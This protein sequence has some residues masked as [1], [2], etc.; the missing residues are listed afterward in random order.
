L[1][2]GLQVD[3]RVV[4]PESLGAALVYFT[5]SKAHN[6]RLRE[7]ALKKGLSLNE[8]GFTKVGAE[9]KMKPVAGRTEQEVYA[10]LGLAWIPPELRE[11]RGEID[12]AMKGKLPRLVEESDVMGDFHNH[13]VLSDGVHTLDQM[14]S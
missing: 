5:G 12:A 9:K 10:K 7:L 4:P 1:A 2:S 14:R 13:T 8:Y 3:F 6:V 11:D